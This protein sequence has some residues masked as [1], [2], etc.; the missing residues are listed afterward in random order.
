[1]QKFSQNFMGEGDDITKNES[2]RPSLREYRKKIEKELNAKY[3]DNRKLSYN[4]NVYQKPLTSHNKYKNEQVEYRK[5]R[6]KG[7]CSNMLNYNKN[8]TEKDKN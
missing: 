6:N 7:S 5:M 8:K 2:V 1:M 4:H 3:K